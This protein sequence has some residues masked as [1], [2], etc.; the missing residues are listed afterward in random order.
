MESIHE[1]NDRDT[2][3]VSF[4]IIKARCCEKRRMSPPSF[5]RALIKWWY[6][7][8]EANFSP[9]RS[10]NSPPLWTVMAV[11]QSEAIERWRVDGLMKKS[12]DRV[13]VVKKSRSEVW[14]GRT[15]CSSISGTI[16]IDWTSSK[17]WITSPASIPNRPVRSAMDK[18]SRAIMTVSNIRR[19][20]GLRGAVC[21][22]WV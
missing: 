6:Q 19:R 11:R 18:P 21:R 16:R 5:S 9:P 22:T 3:S 12:L 15:G 13:F 17:A 2:K 8:W 4:S 10:Q 1:S 7:R 20:C 14:N